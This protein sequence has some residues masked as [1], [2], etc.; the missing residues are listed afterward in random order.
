[1]LFRITRSRLAFPI[2]RAYVRLLRLR[3]IFSITGSPDKTAF[4]M[5]A[6]SRDDGDLGDFPIRVHPR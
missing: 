2:T 5:S 4:P 1:L 3:A 6:M